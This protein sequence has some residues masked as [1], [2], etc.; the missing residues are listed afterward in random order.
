MTMDGVTHDVGKWDLLIAHPPCTYLS[1]AGA[2]RLYKIIDG[3]SYVALERLS[4]GMEAKDFF[5]EYE[6]NIEFEEFV[7]NGV[8]NTKA[9]LPFHYRTAIQDLGFEL[10][11]APTVFFRNSERSELTLYSF[12]TQVLVVPGDFVLSLGRNDEECFCVYI[13]YRKNV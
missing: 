10:Y 11:C 2:S 7:K 13:F 6:E 1:N 3:K 4:K 9:L 8:N 12:L 5:P